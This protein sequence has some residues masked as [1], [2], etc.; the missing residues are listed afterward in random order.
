MDLL[1]AQ[2]ERDQIGRELSYQPMVISGGNVDFG[3]YAQI[4]AAA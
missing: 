1:V 4:M 2:R 3:T